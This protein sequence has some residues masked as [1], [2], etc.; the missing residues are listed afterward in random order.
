MNSI[1]CYGLTIMAGLMVAVN[2]Q[3]CELQPGSHCKNA[4]LTGMDLRNMELSAID[5][6]GA[7]L[8]GADLRHADL[9]GA[10]LEEPT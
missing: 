8:R 10:N 7:D 3:A 9:R 5:L 6:S 4:N 1:K 2:V